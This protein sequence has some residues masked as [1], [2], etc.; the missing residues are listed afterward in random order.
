M[1]MALFA[2]EAWSATCSRITKNNQHQHVA[3]GGR[4]SIDETIC[5]NNC[6]TGHRP[7]PPQL[8]QQHTTA[9]PPT[10]TL[11]H[12]YMSM[13]GVVDRYNIDMQKT[14]HLNHLPTALRLL[15]SPMKTNTTPTSSK[16]PSRSCHKA[17]DPSVVTTI[18]YPNFGN[19]WC[20]C[21]RCRTTTRRRQ[22]TATELHRGI[23]IEPIGVG[24]LSF[25]RPPADIMAAWP[26]TR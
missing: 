3:K 17:V 25:P 16:L 20:I 24:I 4:R 18:S 22:P 2:P 13:G 19:D 15:R 26:F 1:W 8:P 9:P 6:D 5:W 11:N 14:Q 21:S 7:P 12:Q 10:F 23:W